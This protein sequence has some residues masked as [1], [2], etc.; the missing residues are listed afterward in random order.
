MKDRCQRRQRRPKKKESKRNAKQV[1]AAV[2]LG[3]IPPHRP[4]ANNLK[5]VSKNPNNLSTNALNSAAQF[6]HQPNQSKRPISSATDSNWIQNGSGR[7]LG[8]D[9]HNETD[10][11]RK[12]EK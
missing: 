9:E 6:Q 7:R 11:T 12:R 8:P 4:L 5:N 3:T 1:V 2:A 10:R